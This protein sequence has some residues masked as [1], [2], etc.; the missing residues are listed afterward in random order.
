MLGLLNGELF[1]TLR[2]RSLPQRLACSAFYGE[3]SVA[4]MQGQGWY[5]EYLFLWGPQQALW[6]QMLPSLVFCIFPIPSSSLNVEVNRVKALSQYVKR[7]QGE[8]ASKNPKKETQ[9]VIGR[10][11]KERPW[12]FCCTSR[13]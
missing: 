5:L 1:E 11:G 13:V 7:E 10:K 3:F 12:L 2:R 4:G 9:H 8:S 6:A